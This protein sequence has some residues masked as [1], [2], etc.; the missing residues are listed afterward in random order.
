M[1]ERVAM[2]IV[3]VAQRLRVVTRENWRWRSFIV[4]LVV[5]VVV[6]SFVINNI[7]VGFNSFLCRSMFQVS[8]IS[9]LKH[10]V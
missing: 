7:D 9:M 1:I 2:I 4:V 6:R 5:V 10:V 3:P 8:S